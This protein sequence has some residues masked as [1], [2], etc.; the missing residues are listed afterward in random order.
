MHPNDGRVVS[1]FI[2]QALAG[3][4]LTIYGDGMQSRSFCY[5]DD[6]IDGFDRLMR[7]PD[8]FCG[9]VNL[10]NPMEYTM[11]ELAESVIRLTGSC[12]AIVFMPLPSDD[13]VRRKPDISLAKNF[14]AWEPRINLKEGLEKTIDYFRM[15]RFAMGDARQ[16]SASHAGNGVSRVD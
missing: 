16:P 13:P 7:S 10:G 4:P 12:S 6:L 15:L 9:P 8:D 5:V 14:L 1:N 2:M 3:E 11:L